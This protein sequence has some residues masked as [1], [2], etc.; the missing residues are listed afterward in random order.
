MPF[1]G[2]LHSGKPS[3]GDVVQV[4]WFVRPRYDA[5]ALVS[6]GRA[7]YLYVTAKL[8]V[9]KERAPLLQVDRARCQGSGSILNKAKSHDLEIVQIYVTL[10]VHPII[11]WV[12]TFNANYKPFCSSDVIRWHRYQSTLAQVMACYRSALSHHLSQ[13]WLVIS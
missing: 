9:V 13:C 8:D 4:L 5:S 10:S 6:W 7:R 12:F 11:L 1:T 3:E 2:S